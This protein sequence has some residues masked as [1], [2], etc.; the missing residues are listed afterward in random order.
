MADIVLATLNAKYAHTAFGLRYLHANLGA[1]RDRA[2]ILE[3]HI[4]ERPIDILEV[5]LAAAPRVVGLGVYIWNVA[6]TEAVVGLLKAVRPDITVV[7]GGPEVSHETAGQRIVALADHV[8]VGEGEA[9]FPGL[10]Q[11]LL[12][13]APPAA[14]VLPSTLPDLTRLALPYHLYTDVDLAQR[15]VYVEASRGCPY[16][17]EFCLSSLDVSVRR[18]DLGRFLAAMDDLLRRGARQFKFIDRTFNLHLSTSQAILE[19]FW[20]RYTP[21]L[22]LHF[23][24]VPDRLPEGLRETIARFPPGALQFEVGIQ[25]FDSATEKRISRRQNHLKLRDNLT[26]LKAATGVHVHADLIVGLPGESMES[27][28]RGFD[29]LVALGPQE[30]QVGILKRLR[31]T[32]LGRHTA[33]FGMVYGPEP[34]YEILCNDAYSFAAMQ[35]MKRFAR[36]WDMIANRGTFR[37]T[38]PLIWGAGSPFDGFMRLSDWLWGCTGQTHAIALDRLAELLLNFLCHQVGVDE[39]LATQALREDYSRGA[40]RRTPPFLVPQATLTRPRKARNLPRRQA[41]HLA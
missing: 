17:C 30:I 27:F 29:T 4:N 21:E 36:Y 25:T 40:A 3:F 15:V 23:E 18:V 38:T 5:L 2:E 39:A 34:P 1:L 41:Q 33:A 20:E 10:C 9:V 28:G 7:L 6:Q 14:R 19:F 31:G 13:G 37:L 35:R 11:Q 32:P 12:E 26:F 22:F 8:V 24:M 16:A